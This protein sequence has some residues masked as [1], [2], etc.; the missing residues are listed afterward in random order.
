[1]CAFTARVRFLRHRSDG[2]RRDIQ[3]RQNRPH[4]GAPRSVL[5]QV[6]EHHLRVGHRFVFSHNGNRCGQI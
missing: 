5:T 1:M 6:V 3:F 2:F 4:P